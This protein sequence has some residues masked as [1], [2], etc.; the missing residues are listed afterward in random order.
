[1]FRPKNIFVFGDNSWPVDSLIQVL[2]KNTEVTAWIEGQGWVRSSPKISQKVIL[3]TALKLDEAIE[4]FSTWQSVEDPLA[5]VGLNDPDKNKELVEALASQQTDLKILQLKND[6]IFNK[7]L[8]A[9]REVTWE[10]LLSNGMDQELQ[11]LKIQERIHELKKLLQ[12]SDMVALLVQNEPDPDGISS[13]MA[14]RKVLGR[15]APSTPIVSFGKVSR[16]ENRAMLKLLDIEVQQIKEKDLKKFDKIVCLDCQPSFFKS[17]NLPPVSAVIDHHPRN[18]AS[19]K[20]VPFV[21]VHSELG[22]TATLMTQ[23]LM[24]EHIEPSQRLATALLYGIKTDT[25]T[26]HREV[27]FRD[28]EAFLGLY[29]K[30]NLSLI[31]RMEKP[32]I[33]LD[34][35]RSL[36]KSF[37]HLKVKNSIGVL[38]LA[39]VQKEEWIAQAAD[40]LMQIEN[41]KWAIVAG[42]L[43]DNLVISGRNCGY[44]HH[45]GD[46]FKKLFELS[47]TFT[48]M[49]DES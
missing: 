23:F 9:H 40:F 27:S 46:V 34:Y 11:F 44:I 30:A 29:S 20:N 12:K 15:H 18:E 45:C 36:Q 10:N 28:V 47:V 37:K 42:F 49:G 1:M 26:L 35:I 5:I 22:S 2:P 24:A 32:E 41:A 16:P 14:L 7:Q 4:E 13:A 33:P 39:D 43:G 19:L 48:S 8:N 31:K 21:E 17:F 25:L 6:N 38:P 3:K